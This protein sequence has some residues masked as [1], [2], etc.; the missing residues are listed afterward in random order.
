MIMVYFDLKCM[1]G[2]FVYNLLLMLEVIKGV[3]KF[4]DI[5]FVGFD[6]EDGML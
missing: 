6:E 2:F 4:D 1:V 3:G 5:V